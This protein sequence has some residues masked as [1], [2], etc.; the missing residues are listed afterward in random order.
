MIVTKLRW[1]RAKD[2]EDVKDVM[3]VQRDNLDWGYIMGWCK[4][5]GSLR[6]LEEIRGSIP[7]V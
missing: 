5:H 2:K 7:N 4:E 1:A 6:L 3:A